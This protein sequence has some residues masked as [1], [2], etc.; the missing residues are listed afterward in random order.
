MIPNTR[1]KS[2][3]WKLE[4][5]TSEKKRPKKEEKRN[6]QSRMTLLISLSRLHIENYVMTDFSIQPIRKKRTAK[7]VFPTTGSCCKFQYPCVNGLSLLLFWYK[8]WTCLK[9]WHTFLTEVSI[10]KRH[11]F[12]T[13]PR[14]RR[15][16]DADSWVLRD[17]LSISFLQPL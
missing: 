3:F 17:S 7:C 13:Y 16:T 5:N 15:E 4:K 14:R 6:R 9:K 10:W 2:R 11:H 1:M 12:G 8:I